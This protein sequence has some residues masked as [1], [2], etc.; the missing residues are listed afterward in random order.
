[1][2]AIILV[3]FGAQ[4]DFADLPRTPLKT[5]PRILGHEVRRLMLATSLKIDRSKA[6]G[7]RVDFLM[8]DMSPGPFVPVSE[9]AEGVYYQ[10]AHGVH[11]IFPYYLTHGGI[12]VS[13]F[14]QDRMWAF[15]GDARVGAKSGVDKDHRPLSWDELRHFHREE[16][17]R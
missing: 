8:L 5:T 3:G 2:L 9:D 7:K 13:K 16:P 12:Y 4:V 17:Q 1:M 11:V 6:G 14:A 10:A 15:K